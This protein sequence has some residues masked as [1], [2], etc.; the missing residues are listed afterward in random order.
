LLLE[1]DSRGTGIVRKLTVKGTS[2]VGS[3]YEA[4]TGKDTAKCEDLVL[5]VVNRRVC[6]LAIA[7]YLLAVTICKC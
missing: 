1:A 3:R 6:E 7:L 5:A 4:T 2:A